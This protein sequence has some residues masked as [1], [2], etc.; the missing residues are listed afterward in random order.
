MN[1]NK[2]FKMS[3]RANPQPNSVP[4]DEIWSTVTFQLNLV[5]IFGHRVQV[6]VPKDL[7][8]TVG[9]LK[10]KIVDK[11]GS[12]PEEQVIYICL[13]GHVINAFNTLKRVNSNFDFNFL[14]Q[15]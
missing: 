14:H 4:A 10:N 1:W 2:I 13:N 9:S 7:S 15:I 5:W 3:K 12:K 8:M 11:I 6:D